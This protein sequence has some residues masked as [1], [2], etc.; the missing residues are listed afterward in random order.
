MISIKYPSSYVLNNPCERST[1]AYD[2]E[3]QRRDARNIRMEN[4]ALKILIIY[5]CMTDN[6]QNREPR[7][8]YLFYENPQRR[9]ARFIYT[10]VRKYKCIDS[11]IFWWNGKLTTR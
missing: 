6:F 4:N 10:S 9:R 1:A 2:P 11:H 8:F 7:T 5:V 3:S